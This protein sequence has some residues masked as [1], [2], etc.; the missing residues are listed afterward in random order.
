MYNHYNLLTLA[1][2]FWKSGRTDNNLFASRGDHIAPF[3]AELSV[4]VYNILQ[5]LLRMHST[6]M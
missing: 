3:V 4:N 5:V 6:V 2:T 1:V